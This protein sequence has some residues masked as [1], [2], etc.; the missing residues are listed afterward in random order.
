MP[1]DTKRPRPAGGTSRRETGER[2]GTSRVA[3]P[4]DAPGALI[5]G[6]YYRLQP[7]R[8]SF[9][10]S[11]DLDANPHELQSGWDVHIGQPL[12]QG[13]LD[14]NDHVVRATVDVPE[15]MA[16]T[17]AQMRVWYHGGGRLTVREVAIERLQ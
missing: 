6:P 3:E 8:Y 12:A 5:F 7:G 4:A 11:Y 16:G 9:E 17:E 10:L 2:D 13:I 14:P 15:A 1:P